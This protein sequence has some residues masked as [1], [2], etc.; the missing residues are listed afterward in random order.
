MAERPF[1]FRT[2]AKDLS[3]ALRIC[4]DSLTQ[5]E[6]ELIERSVTP[7]LKS[8]EARDFTAP[9]REAARPNAKR[10][11]FIVVV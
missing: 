3:M 11:S 6:S 5:E 7:G 2:L 4:Q 1:Q 9:H 8:E 10:E